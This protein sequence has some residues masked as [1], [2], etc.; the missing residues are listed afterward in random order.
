MSKLP[1]LTKEDHKAIAKELLDLQHEV[2]KEKAQKYAEKRI[3]RL[4]EKF[5]DKQ[6][7]EFKLDML[8]EIDRYVKIKAI[9]DDDLLLIVKYDD[10]ML[11]KL[12][13][14][15]NCTAEHF[16]A[17][18]DKERVLS[19]HDVANLAKLDVFGEEYYED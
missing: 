5:E 13:A 19:L 8:K 6:D 10:V 18:N 4:K 16:H 9:Y 12:V 7:L 1:K 2:E 17:D 15:Y 14:A 3:K 11:D